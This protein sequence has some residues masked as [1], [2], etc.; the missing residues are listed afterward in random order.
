MPYAKS[1]DTRRRLLEAATADF[2]AHG[3]T[4]ARVDRI[5]AA[6]D[7]NKARLYAYFGDKLGLFDAVFRM[8]ADAVV[9]QVPFTADDLAQYAAGLYS[10]ALAHPQ[11]I[12]LTAWARLEGVKPTETSTRAKEAKLQA[13]AQAQR[14]GHVRASLDPE[15]ILVLLIS[16]AL[17]WT[18]PALSEV[19][20]PGVPVPD[21]PASEVLAAAHERRKQALADTVRRAFQP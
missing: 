8:H 3:I 6:A 4:G 19:T 1:E 14:D 7:I 11:L 10:A 17:A 5:A 15:D 13:I 18:E 20:V 21:A 9:D 12:R 16:M 2:A